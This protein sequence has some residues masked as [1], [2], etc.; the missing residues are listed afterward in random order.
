MASG[1]MRAIPIVMQLPFPVDVVQVP[2]AHN[3]EL[4]EALL[5]QALDKP[6]YV[7]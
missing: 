1:L 2:L 5:L 4:V 7:R 3:H 6:F